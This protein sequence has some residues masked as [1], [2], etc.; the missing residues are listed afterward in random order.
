MDENKF[1]EYMSSSGRTFL[2]GKNAKNNEEL[3]SQVQHLLLRFGIVSK[4]R[5]KIIFLAAKL[6]RRILLQLKQ[7]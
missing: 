4:I 5:K 6:K 3:I 2:A 7:K 1:R